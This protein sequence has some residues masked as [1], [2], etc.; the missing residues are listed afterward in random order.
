MAKKEDLNKVFS[1]YDAFLAS[2]GLGLPK[3]NKP[4]ASVFDKSKEEKNKK[5]VN[6]LGKELEKSIYTRENFISGYRKIILSMYD[7]NPS[8]ML[9]NGFDEFE[10]TELKKNHAK[11]TKNDYCQIVSKI[12]RNKEIYDFFLGSLLPEVKKVYE[13]M[14]WREMLSAEGIFAETGIEIYE[15]IEKK[16]FQ[17]KTYYEK[18]LIKEFLV[19]SIETE[20]SYDYNSSSY[21][22][23]FSVEL[24]IQ[25]RRVLMEYYE[26][27]LHYNLIPLSEPPISAYIAQNELE[28]FVTLPNLITYNQQGNIKTSGPGKVMANTLGKIRKTLNINE[29]YPET[30][31]KELQQLKTYLLASLVVC[32]SK[33]KK[34]ETFV[35][36]LK[37]YIN[38]VYIKKYHSHTHILTSLKGGH[39]L[40]NIQNT[41]SKLLEILRQLP[42]NQWVSMQNVIDFASLRNYDLNIASVYEMCNY[43]NYEV[44]GKYGKE[45]KAI[46][47]TNYKKFVNE[48]LLK[49]TLMFWSC[50]GLLDI[51]YD[52]VDTSQIGTT[53]YSVYDGIKAVRLTNLGAYILGLKQEYEAPTVKQS[54]N[55]IFSTDNLIILAEGETNITDNLLVNYADKVSSN[56]YAVSNESFLKN[57][58]SKKELKIKIDIFKQ[59]ISNQLPPNWKEF[60]SNLDQKVHPLTQVDEVMVFKIPTNDPELIKLLIQNQAIKKLLIKAEDYQIIVL[61]KDYPTLRTKLKTYGYLLN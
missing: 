9:K 12:F 21:I 26:K 5:D 41:E 6:L 24:P 51:A 46:T 29:L 40:Y 61:K 58:G 34:E 39:H 14:I 3:E 38:N 1:E 18:E 30:A 37:S 54:Y 7:K 49:G 59:V 28:I 43:L 45:K 27:P 15:S 35:G 44:D 10:I 48:P 19:L 31:P 52:T 60:F 4:K 2:I 22:K 23:N 53:Y 47:K 32:E 33:T 50:Y 42:I 13:A 56:R 55:L 20:S 17:N 16:R 25:L 57:V 36:I 11:L 8:L